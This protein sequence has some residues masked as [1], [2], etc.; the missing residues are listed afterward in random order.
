MPTIYEFFHT[1]TADEIDGLGHVNNLEYL[2]WMQAAAIDHSTAQG[3]P[4]ERYVEAG[5]GWVVRTHTI[6]YLRPAFVGQE[7][8]VRTWVANFK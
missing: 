8:V 3:W 4:P 7:I 1:V 2:K 5:A 6:E